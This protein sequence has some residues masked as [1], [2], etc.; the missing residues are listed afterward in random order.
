MRYYLR[1]SGPAKRA[2]KS[3]K[4]ELDLREVPCTLSQCRETVA[5]MHG[6]SGWRDLL[7]HV[8]QN[9]PSAEDGRSVPE[10]VEHR[11]RHQTTI[12]AEDFPEAAKYAWA[13]VELIGP[14]RSNVDAGQAQA[15]L[16]P[17]E[18][19]Y[20][21]GAFLRLNKDGSHSKVEPRTYVVVA[22]DGGEMR[23][24]RANNI[25]SSPGA[26][27]RFL[28]TNRASTRKPLWGPDAV[29]PSEI[30]R[31]TSNLSLVFE[32]LGLTNSPSET[33]WARRSRETEVLAP[34]F[35]QAE[36]LIS[37]RADPDVLSILRAAAGTHIDTKTYAY[38]AQQDGLRERRLAFA[39]AWPSFASLAIGLSTSSE[40]PLPEAFA[41]S[42]DA[43]T[44]LIKQA[45]DL[46]EASARRCL[47]RLNGKLWPINNNLTLHTVF[48]MLAHLPSDAVPATG[49]AAAFVATCELLKD[50]FPPGLPERYRIAAGIAASAPGKNWCD[51]YE[52][53]IA[54]G[55]ARI[56]KFG[57]QAG[58]S[59]LER[60]IRFFCG[61]HALL[62]RF[63]WRGLLPA[64]AKRNAAALRVFESGCNI[65]LDDQPLIPPRA[66]EASCA[67]LFLDGVDYPAFVD[68]ME[69]T[70]G[71]MF[72]PGRD[73]PAR[74]PV[75]YPLA[76]FATTELAER[77][78]CAFRQLFRPP[79]RDIRLDEALAMSERSM[80]AAG[81]SMA[82]FS[83][84]AHWMD[85]D[86]A[87]MQRRI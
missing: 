4:R 74:N 55:S 75:D 70:F 73:G 43:M 87:E 78:F 31:E 12:L 32:L 86:L 60:A 53:F 46:D 21:A 56:A 45:S 85:D 42:A 82:E 36:K 33:R 77:E 1:S 54:D 13:L 61:T 16:L 44:A 22:T 80:K 20:F 76:R 26:F 65:G 5:R 19:S 41:D 25:F 39:R 24:L 17:I 40:P 34:L 3:L 15:L 47:F 8:G 30:I 71:L 29:S 28:E 27:V 51:R 62:A 72:L 68:L 10:I 64:F 49:D 37:R 2:A 23:S 9:L 66:F 11:W 7:A 57:A 35:E 81:A 50:M 83:K 14:T 63:A 67:P 84:I 79:Y 52:H 48:G 38:Y 69:A 59:R 58:P 6:Y 18:G